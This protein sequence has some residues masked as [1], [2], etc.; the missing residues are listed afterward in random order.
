MARPPKRTMIVVI[1]LAV[2]AVAIALWLV[3]A[4]SAVPGSAAVSHVPADAASVAQDAVS[5]DA[6]RAR[7]ALSP[8]LDEVLPAGTTP[9]PTSTTLQLEPDSWGQ[10]GSYASAFGQLTAPGQAPQRFFVGFVQRDG[11]WR[12]TTLEPAA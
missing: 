10:R 12:V 4:P 2:F 11:R 3:L 9:T 6:D 5:G 1:A 8:A 7:A